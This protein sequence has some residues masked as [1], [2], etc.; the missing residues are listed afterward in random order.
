MYGPGDLVAIRNI[1]VSKKVGTKEDAPAKATRRR[2]DALEL[3]LLEAA[4]DVLA[5]NGFGGFT[6]E[7]VALQARTSRTVLYRRWATISDLAIDALRQRMVSNPVAMPDTGNV[8][9]DLVSFIGD[10]SS[11]RHEFWVLFSVNLAGFF[12]DTVR[13]FSELSERLLDGRSSTLEAILER[14]ARRGEIDRRKLTPRIAAL[15]IHLVRYEAFASLKPP[16]AKAIE[17]IVD[18]IFLPLVRADGGRAGR[19]S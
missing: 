14:A 18:D 16:S 15:P 9:D 5:K 2:G 12:D 19:R 17:E 7:A 13:S 6:M 11:R 10:V 3:S 8:R 1:R 4:W